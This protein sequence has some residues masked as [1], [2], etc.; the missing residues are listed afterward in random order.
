V[1]AI[2]PMQSNQYYLGQFAIMFAYVFAA[3]VVGAGTL[4]RVTK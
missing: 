1:H 3:L 4:R 2:T